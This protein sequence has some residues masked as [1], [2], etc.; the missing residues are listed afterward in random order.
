MRYFSSILPGIEASIIALDT[1][2]RA[3][4]AH[5]G[6]LGQGQLKQLAAILSRARIRREHVVVE[7][8]RRVI[9][10]GGEGHVQ[11]VGAGVGVAADMSAQILEPLVKSPSS[12]G[13]GVGLSIVRRIVEDHGG[14]LKA[15]ATPDGGGRVAMTLPVAD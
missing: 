5:G 4:L 9:G 14:T 12:S 15:E 11:A 13:S 1:A 10:G 2:G 8:D 7:E 3:N 6:N